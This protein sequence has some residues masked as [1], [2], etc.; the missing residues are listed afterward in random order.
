MSVR[1]AEVGG[2]ATVQDLG[3]PGH[4]HEGV[5]ASGAADGLSLRLANRVAGNGDGAAAIEAT[6]G[7]ITLHAIENITLVCSA[8]PRAFEPVVLSAGQ[9]AT[10]APDPG[11]CR[12]YV[13]V[14][15]GI[16]V[17][18]VLGSRSTLSSA[19]FG[20][21][22]GRAL[23][24]GDVLPVGKPLA[25]RR[26]MP[27]HVRALAD[28]AVRS[29]VLRVVVDG[30]EAVLPR[31]LLRVSPRGDRVGIRLEGTGCGLPIETGPSRGVLHGT[32]QAPSSGELVL[33]GPDGPT[34]GGYAT[35]GT[36][37]SADLPALGQLL[38]GQ[39]VRFEVVE[40]E[41]AP[42]YD[43]ERWKAID[44]ALGALE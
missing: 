29:R 11:L 43:L 17:P 34:T 27:T 6:P 26:D 36:V 2:V 28:F 5:P 3:R 4:A 40:R 13:A 30:A 35:V 25:G 12:A 23:C 37:I 38:P 20:G 33:L 39:W 10:F 18:L 19:G 32:I 8:G 24:A 15:G 22:N 9:V 41:I 16:D 21:L 7:R 42:A 1:V 31:G 44:R 14:A